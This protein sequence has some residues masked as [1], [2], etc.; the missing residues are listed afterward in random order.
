[1]KYEKEKGLLFIVMVLNIQENGKMVKRM[2]KEN[3]KLESILIKDIGK[4]IKNMEKEKKNFQLE[5]KLKLHG[6]KIENM[7]KVNGLLQME[8]R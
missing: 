1:M 4:K 6:N 3:L 8:K 5:K 7:E 2:E